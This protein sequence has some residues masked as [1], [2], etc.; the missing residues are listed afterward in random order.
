MKH[1]LSFTI[2]GEPILINADIIQDIRPFKYADTG[3][4]GCRIN[5]TDI[6]Y[7]VDQTIEQVIETLNTAD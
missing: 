1:F 4:M 3:V 2:E 6:N 5:T 7:F